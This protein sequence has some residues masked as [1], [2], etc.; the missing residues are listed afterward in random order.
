MGALAVPLMFAA[1]A[2]GTSI[3][4]TRQTEKRQDRALAEK[5]RQQS[6]KQQEA[7]ARIA[8]TLTG[9]Q[10]SNPAVERAQALA[11]YVAQVRANAAGMGA[12]GQQGGAVSDAYAR[13]AEDAAMGV[14]DYIGGQAEL[15]AR[16][17]AAGRQR[18]RE[19]RT[20][21][22][23][24]T[25]L[26]LIE[27]EAR[28]QAMLDDMRVNSIRRNP[29]LDAASAVLGAMAGGM[30]AGAAAPAGGAAGSGLA[31]G[32]GSTAG[33]GAGLAGGTRYAQ[34]PAIVDPFAAYGRGGG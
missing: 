32:L 12:L 26:G 29:W 15:M 3:Y 34:R 19:G 13:A 9:L 23:L 16:Q 4:N 7:D 8:E 14:S 28:G 22:G 31:S 1:A 25:N 30:G 21:A 11:D 17:D 5:I 33:I 2:A 27:R 18:E 6:K 24:G 20:V 10:G